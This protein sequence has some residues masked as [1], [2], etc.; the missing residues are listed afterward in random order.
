M[1]AGLTTAALLPTTRRLEQAFLTQARALP[2]ASQ[3]LLLLAATDGELSL[4]DLMTAGRAMGWSDSSATQSTV[5]EL[6]V[7]SMFVTSGSSVG[8]SFRS[9]AP[10]TAQGRPCANPEHSCHATGPT[11]P[12]PNWRWHT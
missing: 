5:L 10:R 4:A 9:E 3:Q 7:S 1:A 6:A 12:S 11:Q 8:W 2:E